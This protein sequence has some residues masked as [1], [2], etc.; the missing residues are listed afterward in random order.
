MRGERF[1]VR[2]PFRGRLL[3]VGTLV[4]ALAAGTVSAQAESP[5]PARS[6]RASASPSASLPAS[7]APKR[8][9]SAPLSGQ[10]G[11]KPSVSG[12]VAEPTTDNAVYAYDAAGRLVGVTDPGGETARYRYDAAGNRL[13]VDRFASSQL[14]VLSLVPLRAA[15]GGTVT[16]SG[17]G[18]STTATSNMVTFG[19]KTAEV[20]SASATQLKVKVPAG[21]EAG[22]VAVTI[23]GK[24]V[25]SPESFT[26]APAGPSV[27][28]LAPASGTVDTQVVLSGNG[29]A[30]AATDNVVRFGGGVVA[31]V[32]TRTDTALTVKVPRGQ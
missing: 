4:L 12:T 17:T 31:E 27:S 14:T 20:I 22:K 1:G 10:R 26:L 24:T 6:G 11:D 8:G 25:Q 18:F 28:K 32:V 29:F 21:A 5:I 16:L 23:G 19:S 7:G 9:D 2:L 15:A 13:G 3:T 30:T